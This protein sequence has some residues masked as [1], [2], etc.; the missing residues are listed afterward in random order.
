MINA[1]LRELQL[2][3]QS[4]GQMVP[5]HAYNKLKAHLNLLIK[6]HQAFKDMLVNGASLMQPGQN[7]VQFP[8][9]NSSGI[10]SGSL[11][12]LNKPHELEIPFGF[13]S[14]SVNPI[15]I[16]T[17]SNSNPNFEFKSSDLVIIQTR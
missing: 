6:K 10:G 13:E 9:L 8:A 15:G 1:K 2:K 5:V 4:V 11:P 12:I 14:G 3:E 7:S 17:S 16:P